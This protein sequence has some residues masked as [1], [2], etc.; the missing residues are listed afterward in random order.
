MGRSRMGRPFLYY[1]ENL[2]MKQTMK[3]GHS[4]EKSIK[5]L[6]NV[7]T[8]VSEV[9]IGNTRF[10]VTSECSLTAT[11]TLEQKLLRIMGR[12]LC[13]DGRSSACKHLTNQ[14]FP[15]L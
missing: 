12:H 5:T 2:D 15:A 13:E 11:E 1:Q 9:D 4:N 7:R 10:V 8:H 3:Q 14:P 6:E